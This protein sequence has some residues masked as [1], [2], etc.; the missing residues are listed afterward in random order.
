METSGRPCARLS[1]CLA[2]S[3]TGKGE[4]R[5]APLEGTEAV[6][7]NSTVRA[8][9]AGVKDSP[10]IIQRTAV[11]GPV[12]TVV[13]EGRSREAPPYPDFFYVGRKM[14]GDRP[15]ETGGKIEDAVGDH[16]I[17]TV[18]IYSTFGAFFFLCFL[19]T[20]FTGFFLAAAE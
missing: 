4:A 6:A 14:F 15:F 3:A 2:V 5:T 12:C 1:R 18:R 10:R 19:A 11:Y 17:G 20:F 7:A 8:F 9:G 16:F 13:W